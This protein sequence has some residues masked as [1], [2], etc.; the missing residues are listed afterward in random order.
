MKSI[1][2][3]LCI[4]LIGCNTSL[5]Q[6]SGIYSSPSNTNQTVN[7]I[8]SPEPTSAPS[9]QSSVPNSNG[10]LD[11]SSYE[12]CDGNTI[13]LYGTEINGVQ[14]E[15]FIDDFDTGKGETP[16]ERAVKIGEIN[17]QNGKFSFPIPI[18]NAYSTDSGSQTLELKRGQYYSFVVT[19]K[20]TQTN[21]R[22]PSIDFKY[23]PL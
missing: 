9:N 23:C 11:L 22:H 5:P 6:P 7:N 3:L 16:T 17:V 12:T 4:F 10:N 18:K 15:I 8:L 19:T 13:T 1:L 20:E 14:A 2:S 21:R